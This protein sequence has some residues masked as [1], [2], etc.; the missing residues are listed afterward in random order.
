MIKHQ[1]DG[2]VME[3]K[4]KPEG[5]K[6]TIWCNKRQLDNLDKIQ[7]ITEESVSLI[8]RKGIRMYLNSLQESK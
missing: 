8:I 6:K 1:K 3:E 5:K 2:H 7:D 4:K